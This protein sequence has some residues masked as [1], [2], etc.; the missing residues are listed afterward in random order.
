MSVIATHNVQVLNHYRKFVR[1]LR[2]WPEQRE[3]DSALKNRA[4]LRLQN[5][6]K[7]NKHLTNPEEIEIK[8]EEANQEYSRFVNIGSNKYRKFVCRIKIN[9]KKKIN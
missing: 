6:Y 4:F 1:L 9:G 7:T 2:W 8:M 5:A 3:D